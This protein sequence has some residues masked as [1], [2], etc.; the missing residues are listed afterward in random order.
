[1]IILEGPDGGG[2]STL[3]RELSDALDIDIAPRVVSAQAKAMTDLRVWTEQNVRQGFQHKIF[4]RHR[5]I[6]APIYDSVLNR[7][8]PELYDINW[9]PAMMQLFYE[10]QPIIIYCLPP[11]DEVKGNVFDGDD[12]NS[13]VEGHIELIY[14]AYVAR[15]SL[16]W[17]RGAE[18][19]DYTR[20]LEDP[21]WPIK[22]VERMIVSRSR[23]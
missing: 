13:V 23:G 10:C 22:Y 3:A 15:A 14:Q 2:K 1:M 16:D 5:L 6:S 21:E 4:D 9:L 18:I 12:D 8:H 20:D 19:F 11:L 17:N 7:T